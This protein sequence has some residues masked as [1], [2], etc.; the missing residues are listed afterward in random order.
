MVNQKSRKAIKVIAIIGI[1]ITAASFVPSAILGPL[2]AAIV[3]VSIITA[4]AVGAGYM[5]EEAKNKEKPP[6]EDENKNAESMVFKT[7]SIHA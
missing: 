2:G 7:N 1:T 3:F 4:L 6:K 5:A